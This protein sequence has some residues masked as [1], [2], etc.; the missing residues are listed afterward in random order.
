MDA[1]QRESHLLGGFRAHPARPVVFVSLLCAAPPPEAPYAPSRR[2][3]T[4]SSSLAGTQF[5]AWLSFQ[6]A[7]NAGL[8]PSSTEKRRCTIACIHQAANIGLEDS[9]IRTWAA[10]SPSEAYTLL[11]SPDVIV[12]NQGDKDTQLPKILQ[13]DAAVKREF[14]R[15]T[16]QFEA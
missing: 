3:D 1:D 2:A 13:L 15:Y 12:T 10:K 5:E 14:A 4:N 16:S 9:L 7:T 11:K 6:K 8:R